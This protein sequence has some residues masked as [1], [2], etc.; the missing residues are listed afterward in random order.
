VD[1]K[2]RS[3][4]ESTPLPGTS[5]PAGPAEPL[6]ELAELLASAT[7]KPITRTIRDELHRL[8]ARVAARGERCDAVSATTLSS[9]TTPS[10]TH[11]DLDLD[12]LDAALAAGVP[13]ADP[14]PGTL[15]HLRAWIA[16]PRRGRLETV[17]ADPRFRGLLRDAV[18]DG[19]GDLLALG[20]PG[21]VL[22][23]RQGAAEA[24]LEAPGPADIV[25][26]QVAA[27]AAEVADRVVADNPAAA[28]ASAG[29]RP[30]AG[31]HAGHSAD[32]SDAGSAAGSAADRAAGAAADAEPARA[33]SLTALHEAVH[34]LDLLGPARLVGIRP[35]TRPAVESL[36]TADVPA[37]LA[38]A[39]RTGIPDELGDQALDAYGAYSHTD[40]VFRMAADDGCREDTF[41]IADENRSVVFGPRG[42]VA[43]PLHLQFRLRP[44]SAHTFERFR[45]AD[46]RFTAL[47]PRVDDFDPDGR[48]RGIAVAMPGVEASVLVRRTAEGVWELRGPDGS[49]GVRWY[50]GPARPAGISGSHSVGR[51]RHRWAAGSELLTPPQVWHR[52]VA[53]DGEGSRLLR[54]ADRRFAAAVLASAA[55]PDG[56]RER[57]V[58]ELGRRQPVCNPSREVAEA[59]EALRAAIAPHFAGAT[60]ERLLDGIAGTVWTAME[61]R[62]LAGR[63]VA[64]DNVA[65]DNASGATD[66]TATGSSSGT[67]ARAAARST[68]SPGGA[69]PGSLLR[70][71]PAAYPRADAGDLR[72]RVFTDMQEMYQRIQEVAERCADPAVAVPPRHV[73]LAN[74]LGWEKG[75]GR[76][77]GRAL[78]SSLQPGDDDR[79]ADLRQDGLRSCGV[80][81]M[82]DPAGLWRTMTLDTGG[83]NSP[84]EGTVSRTPR[85]CVIILQRSN[86][87]PVAALEYAADG[88]FGAPP[89]GSATDVR[90]CR[91]W[92]GADRIAALLRLLDERGTAPWPGKSVEAFAAATRMSTVRAA[93]LTVGFEPRDAPAVRR[94]GP[95]MT[96]QFAAAAGIGRRELAEAGAGLARDVPVD[97]RLELPE[98]LMPDDPED[99]WRDR[100]AV[101]RAAAWWNARIAET[102]QAAG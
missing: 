102:G 80:A 59:F 23:D 10:G 78:R 62:V 47:P 34:Y 96:Q 70:G 5:G 49:R 86:S 7:G 45:Y 54:A 29:A 90:V 31:G 98:F 53:R 91:G 71:I 67:A 69:G 79:S 26:E 17:A 30:G 46:G 58:A 40:D 42:V 97:L 15:L 1:E 12:L 9:W 84:E 85:G 25:A 56:E 68:G 33:G 21:C 100:L 89:F 81:P 76:L 8:G 101:D 4:D 82:S 51:H 3:L 60:S 75:L 95:G 93:I 43:G 55:G 18:L 16:A 72:A 57:A 32:G 83:R 65:T 77:G 41:V 22:R 50:Q 11:L 14:E 48:V 94:G 28:Q 74:A 64:T 66:G 88:V 63:H 38:A 87:G 24:V 13:V 61:I 6:A 73:A 52:L 44:G 92:G 20:R 39:W 37:L 99:L 2:I 36:L 35:D 27:W 19:R